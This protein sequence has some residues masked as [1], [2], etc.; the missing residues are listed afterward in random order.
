[1]RC[2]SLG[3]LDGAETAASMYRRDAGWLA[4]AFR[5]SYC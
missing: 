4:D 3:V 2:V 5:S 1:M